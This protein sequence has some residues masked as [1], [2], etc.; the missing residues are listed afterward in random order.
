MN[1][2]LNSAATR[3]AS[4]IVARHR[5]RPAGLNLRSNRRCR[6]GLL[7]PDLGLFT[8]ATAR[9]AAALKHQQ[10]QQTTTKE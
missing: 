2:Y 10:P 1:R 4:K 5:D 6:H 7:V 8:R 3:R 9:L